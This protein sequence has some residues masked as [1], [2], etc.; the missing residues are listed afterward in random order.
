[1]KYAF[2]FVAILSFASCSS[3]KETIEAP[4]ISDTIQAKQ[5]VPSDSTFQVVDDSS[6]FVS[7]VM[8]F[9]AT[10]EFYVPVYYRQS[11]P[12]NIFILNNTTAHTQYWREIIG[13]I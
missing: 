7:P 11:L 9:E 8:T 5:V 2:I 1:M 13:R 4:I 12:H 3:K 10:S 6:V